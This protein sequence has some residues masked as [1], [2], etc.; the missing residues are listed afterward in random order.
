MIIAPKPTKY[1]RGSIEYSIFK[2]EFFSGCDV[3][4]YFG[5]IYIDEVINLDFTLQEKKMPIFG[6]ASYTFDAIA[7]GVRLIEG[8]FSI[9]FKESGYLKTVYKN[10]ARNGMEMKIMDES[11]ALITP[12]SLENF[13]SAARNAT[14][15]EFDILIQQHEQ[16]FWGHE[17]AKEKKYRPHFSFLEDIDDESPNELLDSGFNILITYGPLEQNASFK[18]GTVRTINDVFITGVNQVVAPSGQ[19]I[20]E[21]YSF[22]ARDLDGDFTSL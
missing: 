3:A 17:E 15:E 12:S 18:Y 4:V 11:K 19:P 16:I 6:Y 5:D 22:V 20:Y 8:T 21:T 14:N 1:E 10:I 9:V 13:I 2:N 7:H